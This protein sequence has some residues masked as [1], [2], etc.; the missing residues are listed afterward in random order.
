MRRQAPLIEGNRGPRTSFFVEMLVVVCLCGHQKDEEQALFRVVVIVASRGWSSNRNSTVTE[1][2]VQSRIR[3]G[4][5]SMRHVSISSIA[6]DQHSTS[7]HHLS[8]MET[9]DEARLHGPGVLIYTITEGDGKTFPRKGDF[10]LVRDGR[11]IHSSCSTLT[12][13]PRQVSRLIHLPI[14]CRLTTNSIP[15]MEPC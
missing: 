13:T 3:C 14:P 4:A 2:L 11:S 7:P 15:K 8:T 9:T 12:I 10:C 1:W 5:T 6:H